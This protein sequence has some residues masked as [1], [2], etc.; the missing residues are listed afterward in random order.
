MQFT[1]NAFFG[2]SPF[3]SPILISFPSFPSIP[4]ISPSFSL[5][6]QRKFSRIDF[7]IWFDLHDKALYNNKLVHLVI[8]ERTTSTVL[9]II[10]VFLRSR[11]DAS[12]IRSIY[13]LCVCVCIYRLLALAT[14]LGK[15]CQIY[16]NSR[17]MVLK[18]HRIWFIFS[19]NKQP[20]LG[21]WNDGMSEQTRAKKKLL[22]QF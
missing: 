5:S 8:L 20:V 7:G 13:E 2:V 9:H 21:Y 14:I 3:L 17:S 16:L 18:M 10:F 4:P 19:N 22:C 11:S 1:D 15:L 6:S 12:F